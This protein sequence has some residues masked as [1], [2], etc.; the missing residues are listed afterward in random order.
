MVFALNSIQ[1]KHLQIPNVLRW[2]F[3]IIAFIFHWN[4]AI[5]T[6]M[7][8]HLI[9]PLEQQHKSCQV[10][11]AFTHTG[12]FRSPSPLDWSLCLRELAVCLCLGGAADVRLCWW[13]ALC[14]HVT[15]LRHWVKG[16][17]PSPQGRRSPSA[18][19][20]MTHQLLRLRPHLPPLSLL[21]PSA[22][23]RP[24]HAPPLPTLSAALWLDWMWSGDQER[25]GDVPSVIT[26]WQWLTSILWKKYN[27]ISDEKWKLRSLLLFYTKW[28][29]ISYFSF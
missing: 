11:S 20:L 19:R 1:W 22:P 14:W 17:R 13:H 8:K 12:S 25:G 24:S 26:I 16:E 21:P 4:W 3:R 10:K 28:I 7:H 5:E 15:F 9:C 18:W 6:N 23:P 29:A 2:N 27:E